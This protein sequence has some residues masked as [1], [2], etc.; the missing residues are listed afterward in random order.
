M[1]TGFPLFL[2]RLIQRMIPQVTPPQ[3]SSAS[4]QGK[5]TELAR[6]AANIPA[7][8]APPIAQQL[9]PLDGRAPVPPAARGPYPGSH[10]VG[11]A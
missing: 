3:T 9:A 2:L 4:H 11:R 10:I 6:P 8:T 5:P 1:P 7:T